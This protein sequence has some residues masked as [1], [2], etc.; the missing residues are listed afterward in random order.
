MNYYQ[1]NKYFFIIAAL[2]SINIA[3]ASSVNACQVLCVGYITSTEVS[4]S[5]SS[6]LSSLDAAKT[7]IEQ[8]VNQANCGNTSCSTNTQQHIEDEREA[9]RKEFN[10][11]WLE[12]VIWNQLLS[13]TF[14]DIANQ[15]TTASTAQIAI[16]GSFFDAQAHID[17]QRLINKLHAEAHNKYQPSRALCRFGTGVR[18]LA[19]SEQI[20]K[21]TKYALNQRSM[22]R[23]MGNK[24]SIRA[25]GGVYDQKARMK[26]F[27]EIYCDY[28]DNNN[29]FAESCGYNLTTPRIN[30]DATRIAKDINYTAVLSSPLTIDID[31]INDANPSN[32]EVDVLALLNNLIAHQTFVRM[33]KKEA[34]NPYNRSTF[35][36]MRSIVAKR[37]V[38]F[39][40]VNHI[41]AQKAKGGSSS[42]PYLKKIVSELG[43]AT[44]AEVEKLIGTNPSYYAQMEVLTKKLYQNPNFY[45]GLIDKP[46][47]VARQHA[48]IQSFRM[49]QKRDIYESV[50]RTEMLMSV[51]LETKLGKLRNE[52]EE[53][54]RAI[55]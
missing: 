33:S 44:P 43:I 30:N 15:V 4:S 21:I 13:P 1:L 24:N 28:A 18:S 12:G 49:M 35:L 37:N 29:K 8:A 42:A 22:N 53:E 36:N 52:A 55:K 7:Q 34:K 45:I 32:D 46:E 23:Q 41:I 31:F 16:I 20:S 3:T 26:Q 48:A 19:E 10:E 5:K 11:D 51:L 38:I 54:L 50:L 47:N 9:T 2:L 27:A 40:S 17:G 25:L 6:F 14:R 39:N